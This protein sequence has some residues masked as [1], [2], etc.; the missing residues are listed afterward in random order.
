MDEIARQ[1]KLYHETLGTI[2]ST[3]ERMTGKDRLIAEKMFSMMANPN[4]RGN[5]RENLFEIMELMDNDNDKSAFL[6]YIIE[7]CRRN[8]ERGTPPI[9]PIILPPT[10]EDHFECF[11]HSHTEFDHEGHIS[12]GELWS[13]YREWS[14]TVNVRLAQS[15]NAF[16]RAMQKK[17]LQREINGEKRYVNIRWR[18]MMPPVFE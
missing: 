7:G 9:P 15:E 13:K 1:S 2:A 18:R 12:A 14:A 6:N 8:Y 4:S 5:A 16:K 17:G 10:E 3:K 11:I